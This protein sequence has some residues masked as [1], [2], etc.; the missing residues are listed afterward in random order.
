MAAIRARLD[1]SP[2][3]N[4]IRRFYHSLWYAVLLAVL[5]LLSYIFA[6]EVPIW[7]LM[8]AL[9]CISMV[10]CKDLLPTLPATLMA[11]F[12][13][14]FAHSPA[15][16]FDSWT[17][18]NP[19]PSFSDY[20]TRPS[21]L[22]AIGVML[23][24]ILVSYVLHQLLW[25]DILRVFRRPTT[26][27]ITIIPLALALLFNGAFSGSYSPLNLLFGAG[28]VLS[29]ILFYL[30]DYHHMPHGRDTIRYVCR[31]ACIV[32]LLLVAEM[33]FI[34]I[35]RGVLSGGAVDTSKIHFGWGVYNCFGGIVALLIPL[36]FYLAIT[37]RFGGVYYALGLV[38]WVA[39][40]LST[41][42][43]S[44][45]FGTL[46]LLA[47]VILSCF[48]GRHKRPYRIVALVGVACVIAGVALFWGKI[49]ELVPRYMEVLLDDS[50]R[51][52]IWKMGLDYWLE[53]PFLGVGFFGIEKL[54]YAVNYA[55]LLHNTIIELMA[56]GGTLTLLAY[57]FYRVKTAMLFFRRPT[58]SRV[59]LGMSILVLLGTSLLD[60][61]TFTIYPMFYYAIVLSLAEHDYQEQRE[62]HA[63][64]PQSRGA[65][66]PRVSTGGGQSKD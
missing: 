9:T 8:V 58:L 37:E 55:G 59:F 46:A 61:H 25:G 45:L 56:A 57:L 38:A 47:C 54:S 2:M 33:V 29:W 44:L 12:A 60:I 24:A 48:V 13:L 17:P 10:V 1:D 22:T 7:A 43:S 19:Y 14:S 52:T 23:G 40:F 16:N 39:I 49:M 32:L 41:S 4:G 66:N 34:F 3:I 26:L 18:D 21:T 63:E 31:V 42:R 30:V 50:E 62:P 15:R 6:W 11:V 64:A 20:M 53:H 28:L 65:S 36:I 5:V 27:T 51:F 35:S